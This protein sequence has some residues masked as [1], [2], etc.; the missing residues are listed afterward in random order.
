MQLVL[1]RHGIAVDP[2][3]P[4]CPTDA[5]RPLTERGRRRTREVAGGLAALGV[6]V[7][8]ILSSPLVRAVQTAE[9]AAERLGL[10][11]D[12]LRRTNALLPSSAPNGLLAEVQKLGPGGVLCVGHAPHLDLV[13]AAAVT[14]GSA[15]F[16]ALKKAGA[17]CLELDFPPTGGR[18]T[19]LWMMDPRALRRLVAAP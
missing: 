3:D 18:A 17:A 15:P 13:L 4:D 2:A 6:R 9:I 19:L 16:T 12:Q 14:P 8:V 5:Q 7:E 10:R 1:L 11:S